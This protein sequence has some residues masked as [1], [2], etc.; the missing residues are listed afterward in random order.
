MNMGAVPTESSTNEGL[1]PQERALLLDR[2]TSSRDSV[3]RLCEHISDEQ[4]GT[5]ARPDAWSPAECIEH[6]ILSEEAL[7]GLVRNDILRTEPDRSLPESVR[8]KD[9]HV[10]TGLLDRS[11]RLRTYDFLEPSGRW[12]TQKAA[13]D[14]FLTRREATISYVRSTEDALHVHGASF[15]ALGVLDG[16][17]W[18]LAIAVHTERHVAQAE[19]TSVVRNRNGESMT[20]PRAETIRI[21]EAYMNG[22]GNRDFSRVPFAEDFTYQSP[23]LPNLVGQPSLSGAAAIEF[24][25]S[26]FPAI[27]GVEIRQH[28]VEGE[29]C[30]SQFDL[31]T[32][33]G[34]IP[35]LDRF[36]VVGGRLKL[37]NPFYDPA[38]ILK[39]QE[40]AQEAAHAQRRE[41]LKRTAEAYFRALERADFAGIPFSDDVLF[42]APLAPG[43]AWQPLTGKRALEQVWWPPLKGAIGK[44]EILEHYVND[45]A[46]CICTAALVSVAGTDIVL[47]V[48]D[49][50]TVDS[51]GL[52]TEQENHF[53]PRDLTNPG[54]SSADR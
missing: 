17:Q 48:T 40:R 15:G 43:G 26:L 53:D 21:V 30:V 50:F 10:V 54:W 25:Q 36:H 46:T 51:T 33:H 13:W 5:K 52:I 41:Q 14:A 11:T 2:L 38:P 44:V 37:A 31:H 29:Y 49:R 47:R 23:L 19:V 45:D 12:R 16:Y 6:L 24:L 27:T 28:I 4:W 9:G 8:G 39:G 18:L 32:I 22:L 42:R 35:V 7:L 3:R 1:S 20:D 34:T